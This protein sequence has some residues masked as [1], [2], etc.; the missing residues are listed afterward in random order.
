MKKVL[1]PSLIILGLNLSAFSQGMNQ[2]LGNGNNMGIG[3]NPVLLL[4]EWVSGEV[5][6]WNVSRSAE[7][8]IPFQYVKNP[9]VFDDENEDWDL[10][11]YT[12]GVYYRY[13]FSQKQEGFFAQAGWQYAGASVKEGGQEATGSLNSILFG[14]GYRLISD[15]GLFWGCGLSVGRAWG[16]VEAPDGDEVQGSGLNI[17]IDLLKFGYAW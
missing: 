2:N 3:L 16:K 6:L 5:N 17:D 11:Y 9:F 1:I 7:I 14:F 15:G 13:F 4:F 8:N 12:I 10:R